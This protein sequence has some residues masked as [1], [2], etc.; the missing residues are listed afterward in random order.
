M[1]TIPTP[2]PAPPTK[3]QNIES[4]ILMA[5]QGLSLLPVVGGTASI[6]GVF[7]NILVKAQAAYQ[8]ES[9]QPIDLSKIPLETP[10][11]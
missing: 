9:G 2:S 11:A 5:L 3:L 4:I 1:S 6:I 10:V 8:Q 7:A